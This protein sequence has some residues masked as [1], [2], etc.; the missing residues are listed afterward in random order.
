MTK[1]LIR[2]ILAVAPLALLARPAHA[3]T[4]TLADLD[5]DGVQD[6]LLKADTNK[7]QIA[8]ITVEQTQTTIT[9]QCPGG[10][11]NRVFSPPLGVI[12]VRYADVNYNITGVL[13]GFHQAVYAKYSSNFTLGGTGSLTANS[14]IYLDD[15]GGVGP[16]TLNVNLPP[17]IDNSALRVRTD[18]GDDTDQ[19]NLTAAGLITGNSSVE[20]RMTSGDG[21]RAGANGLT[22]N[23]SGQLMDGSLLVDFEGGPAIDL[24][25]GT[26]GGEIGPNGRLT[27]RTYLGNGNDG[28]NQKI[29]S[30]TFVVDPGGEVRYR[31]QGG[32]GNDII[33][34]QRDTTIPLITAADNGEL[35]VAIDGGPGADTITVDLAG[36]GMTYNGLL[37]LRVDG[38]S[39]NDVT[40]VLLDLAPA[41]LTP[42]LDVFVGGESGNDTTTF[43]LNT[44]GAPVDY[45]PAGAAIVHGGTGTTDKCVVGGV[46][47]TVVTLGCEL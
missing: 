43:N 41:S 17:V 46:G 47:G 15:R 37:R 21:T 44:N 22:F 40:K 34:F 36:G 13:A 25:K 3:C 1:A 35:D 29:N 6:I 42:K 10:F 9:F 38:D 5:G 28:F 20:L 19:T 31:V 14:S 7:H 30:S 11:N 23:H 24:Y 45:G 27:V 33:L 26:L 2:T 32:D 18:L 8:T 12:D 16:Q 4:V 39:G